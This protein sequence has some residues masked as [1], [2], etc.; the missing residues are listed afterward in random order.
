MTYLIA[1]GDFTHVI[2]G[3]VELFYFG[4]DA[5][6]RFGGLIATNLFPILLGNV[7]GGTG[8]FTLIAWAQVEAE[9]KDN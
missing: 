7:L 3:S 5:L 2:A 9:M 8:L 6:E 4:L 1:L